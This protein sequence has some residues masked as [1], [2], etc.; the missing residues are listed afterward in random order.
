[1]TVRLLPYTP[2]RDAYRLLGIPHT[3]SEEEISAACR[4]LA[5][6]F[7]PD[8]NRSARATEEMQVVNAV[9][10]V[11]SD[12]AWRAIYDRERHRFHA[13][14]GR[15]SM[16]PPARVTLA[17]EAV[18]PLRLPYSQRFP[19]QRHARAFGLGLRATLVALLPPR[20]AGC[21]LAVERADVYCAACGL[22]VKSRRAGQA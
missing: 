7:H 4:R 5:M 3:A 18:Q 8:R 10:Q 22:R 9:R 15:A 20:C 12:P 17:P 6:A 21:G 14:L 19:L 1:M 11:M 16:R 2:D 13:Q